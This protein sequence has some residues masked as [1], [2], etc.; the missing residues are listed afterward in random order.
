MRSGFLLITSSLFTLHSSAN[1]IL[2]ASIRNCNLA[3]RIT[4]PAA[5]GEAIS[6]PPRRI[7]ACLVEWFI[8]WLCTNSPNK[9]QDW[10][11]ILRGRILS[12]PTAAGKY[13][14]TLP[15]NQPEN[16]KFTVLLSKD[17]K[18]IILCSYPSHWIWS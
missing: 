12:S 10:E 13:R 3:R 8:V 4:T 9:I 16:F 7:T 5:V 6:L 14:Y 18:D 17:D 2:G 1:S 11:V 15:L